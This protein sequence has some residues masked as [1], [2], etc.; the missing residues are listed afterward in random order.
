MAAGMQLGAGQTSGTPPEWIMWMPAGLH[1]ITATRQGKPWTGRVLVDAK[2]AEVAQA[3]LDAW[4]AEGQQRPWLDFNHQRQQA[5]GWPMAFEF[6]T[7]PQPGVYVRVMWSRDG[8]DAILGRSYRSFSPSFFVDG[9]EPARVAALPLNMGG[10]V[11]SPAFEAIKPIWASS[12]QTSPATNNAEKQDTNMGEKNKDNQQQQ[13]QQAQGVQQVDAGAAQGAGMADPEMAAVIAEN[14]R[15]RAADQARRKADA[16]TA[17][18]AAIARGAIPPK[19]AKLKAQ[20]LGLIEADPANM[21]LLANLPG[22][23]A[24]GGARTTPAVH[25]HDA[26]QVGGGDAVEAESRQSAR[27]T[28]EDTRAILGAYLDAKSPRER[29]VLYAGEISARLAAGESL[30][31]GSVARARSNGDVIEASNSLGT[32]AG[33]LVLQRVLEQLRFEMPVLSRISTDL[34]DA[35][36]RYGQTVNV[37]K[38]T[39]PSVVS[40]NTSTGFASSDIT[41]TDVPVVINAHKAVQIDINVQDMASTNRDLLGEQTSG[42]VYALSADFFAA[43]WALFL[44]ANYSNKTTKALASF[45]RP[46]VIAMGTALTKRKVS[47][48]KRS[49]ILNPDYYGKLAEDTTVVAIQTNPDA[50]R[51]ITTGRLPDLH[52]FGLMESGF[53]VDNS[54]NLQGVAFAPSAVA[55]AARVPDDYTK[56]FPGAAAGSRVET[57]QDPV[58]GLAMMLVQFID[59]K[60]ARAYQRVAI[61]YGVAKG[62]TEQL[63]RLISS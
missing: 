62:D 51:S 5:S 22:N 10:L 30:P 36:I 37:Q 60:L 35:T 8:A 2:T 7:A 6:R 34:S 55:F 52:G 13:Q 12:G 40:Y 26:G 1:E 39:P 15:L 23:P 63:E 42:M 59:H 56:V 21:V 18:N 44:N 46:T 29:G 38:L 48:Y 32:L 57:I 58:S 28:R 14:T 33:A 20:W 41:A 47:K 19:D 16:E 50:A 25:A 61:M 27:I 3:Q 49:L 4:S 24:L 17:V 11:N 31:L 9:G 43:L 53:A 45:A 54:E